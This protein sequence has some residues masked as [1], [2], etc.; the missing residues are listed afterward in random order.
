MLQTFIPHTFVQG[1]PGQL[2]A[3]QPVRRD[4]QLQEPARQEPA[5]DQGAQQVEHIENKEAKGWRDKEKHMK[6]LTL[7]C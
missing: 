4:P 1:H 7:D 2:E 6:H 5:P 3:L